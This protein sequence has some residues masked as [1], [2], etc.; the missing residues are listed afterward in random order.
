MLS[1]HTN[2]YAI[3]TTSWMSTISCIIPT[4]ARPKASFEI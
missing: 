1:P 2:Q 3:I 4:R